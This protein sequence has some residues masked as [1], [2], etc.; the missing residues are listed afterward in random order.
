MSQPNY[1]STSQQRGYRTM[2]ALFGHEV[3][4]ISATDLAKQLGNTASQAYKDLINLQQAGLA[5]QL[6][7]GN[8]RIAP[9]LGRECFRILNNITAMARRIDEAMERYGANQLSPEARAKYF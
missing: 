7:N 4:G 3:T 1:T 2:K 8:W 9:A 5:E 6:P